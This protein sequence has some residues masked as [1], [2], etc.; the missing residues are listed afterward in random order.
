MCRYVSLGG[1]RIKVKLHRLEI[2]QQPN[3]EEGHLIVGKLLPKT[4]ARAGVER[5]ED[6]GIGGE[7]FVN[8]IVEE[9]V[10]V[11]FFR[12]GGYTWV[13]REKAGADEMES[14]TVWSPI[15]CPTMHAVYRVRN[16]AICHTD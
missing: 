1:L 10:R 5:E 2:L 11:E 3:K 6:E 4:D 8:A 7:V 13:R 12:C 16:P 9:A 15:I 14:I